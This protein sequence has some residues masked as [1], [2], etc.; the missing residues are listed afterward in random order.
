MIDTTS[1]TMV[2]DGGLPWLVDTAE[3]A[4]ALPQY[5]TL[6]RTSATEAEITPTT[7][8]AYS[9]LCS[10]VGADVELEDVEDVTSRMR[11]LPA[12]TSGA[13]VLRG[14]IR[15]AAIAAFAARTHAAAERAAAQDLS[16]ASEA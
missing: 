8:D 6:A 9:L 5:Y 16:E 2:A 4:A 14:A 10:V 15:D 13:Y 1:L 11:Y 7:L 12:T 3:L